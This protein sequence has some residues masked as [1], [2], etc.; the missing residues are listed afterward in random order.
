MSD[1]NLKDS[2]FASGAV[3]SA[4]V[5]DM[6][7][8]SLPLLGLLGAIKNAGLGGIK[9]GRFN[10][11]KGMPIHETL[12]HVAIHLIKYILGDRSEDHLSKV[13][14][15]AMVANQTALLN[16]ET[17]EP[18]MLGPGATL[19][20]ALLEEMERGKE[21]R[22]RRR[23]NGEFEEMFHIGLGDIQQVKDI[24]A[25]RKPKQKKSW[26]Q[27]VNET[28]KRFIRE[29]HQPILKRFRTASPS[30]LAKN[31]DLIAD[32]TQAE[33]L[34]DECQTR[35]EFYQVKPKS[36]VR[37]NDTACVHATRQSRIDSPSPE[38][39]AEWCQRNPMAASVIQA[40][41]LGLSGTGCPEPF[42]TFR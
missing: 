4:D 14:W 30:E 27:A 24:L 10:Y 16:P 31:F 39:L 22:D 2:N 32:N 11:M 40:G 20:K 12:N 15:G 1:K 38:S 36:V 37:E 7:F 19:G 21:E 18:H 9:Y 33:Y 29:K 41:A 8:C 42:G 13:A 17:A 34:R 23:Q 26:Q 35:D 28:I 6:D 3:R 5:E 25:E